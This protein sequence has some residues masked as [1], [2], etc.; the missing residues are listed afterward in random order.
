MDGAIGLGAR[1]ELTLVMLLVAAAAGLVYLL[2]G[3][4][5]QI[6]IDRYASQMSDAVHLNGAIVSNDLAELRRDVAFLSRVPPIQG[7]LR[8]AFNQGVDPVE[9]NAYATW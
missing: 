9:G 1:T 6:L 7:M 4:E 3:H 2:T 5:R 8:A